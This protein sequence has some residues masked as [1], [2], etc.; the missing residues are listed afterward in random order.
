MPDS[1]VLSAGRVAAAH[2]R[3]GAACRLLAGRGR[4]LSDEQVQGGPLV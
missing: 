1:L 4:A 3:L 2:P